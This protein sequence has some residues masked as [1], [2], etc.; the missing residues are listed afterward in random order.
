MQLKLAFEI[1][2][3]YLYTPVQ[4]AAQFSPRLLPYLIEKCCPSGVELL[5][6]LGGERYPLIWFA[7]NGGNVDALDYILT[8]APRGL[9]LLD[10]IFDGKDF[11]T[12]AREKAEKNPNREDLQE[13]AKYLAKV[14]TIFLARESDRAIQA[15]EDLEAEGFELPALMLGVLRDNTGALIYRESLK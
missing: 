12:Y 6:N 5:N 15:L 14:K 8:H 1:R 9:T 10:D 2:P 3:S 4:L 7:I 13:I 11:W